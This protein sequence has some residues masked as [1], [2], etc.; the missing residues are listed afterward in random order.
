MRHSALS[1]K[2][3]LV[4]LVLAVA[5]VGCS[6]KEGE[7]PASPTGIQQQFTLSLANPHVQAVM[8]IQD[9]HTAKLMADP[10][11][12]G[13]ATG[14]TDDGKPAV[15]IL[16]KSERKLAQMP[17]DIEGAPVIAFVSGPIKAL[18]G[19]GGGVSHTAR[20][21]R[22]IQ[23]GTSGGNAYDLANGYCC[24]GTLGA[25][26]VKN[27]TQYILSNSHVLCGDIAA[28]STDPDKAQIGDPIDQP[29]L[30]DV[31]CQ[32]IPADYVANLSTLSSLSPPK[33]VDCA[34]AQVIAGK[35]RTDGAIL[36]VGVLS[37]QTLAPTVGLAV[38]KSGR[39]SGLTRSSIYGINAS[40]TVGYEDE[41]N[42][43]AFNV[44]YTGQILVTNRSSRF[45]KA[46]DS[47]SLL[48]QDV[49]T[50]PKAVGLLFAGSTSIAVANP[51]SA[52]LSYLGVT[53]VG[54]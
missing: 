43:S 52:V 40:V 12:V 13:T 5:L 41:C 35:V 47:G 34:M 8:A 48:V 11:V 16:L 54:I 36:E 15:L 30:I 27:G 26:V 7:T 45:L 4:L 32:A 23:L 46:G 37:S 50:N 39:T 1:S 25:L 20:Q 18:K 10:E 22:P 14:M 49:T 28:S 38:K 9:K 42:G 6:K 19:G 2:L 44:S 3:L 29:G 31:N 33:N 51:I 24:S 17:K 53:M 21:T